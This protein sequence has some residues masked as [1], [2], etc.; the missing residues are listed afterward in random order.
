M[1]Q[2]HGRLPVGAQYRNERW[3]RDQYRVVDVLS[4]RPFRVTRWRPADQLETEDEPGLASA[5]HERSVGKLAQRRTVM[6]LPS[7]VR[8]DA[9]IVELPIHRIGADLARV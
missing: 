9:L 8:V 2:W 7:T 1:Q 3:R 4:P 6:T 5:P